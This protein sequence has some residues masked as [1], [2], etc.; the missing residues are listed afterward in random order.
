MNIKNIIFTSLVILLPFVPYAQTPDFIID[1]LDA[2]MQREMERWQIPGAAIAIVKDGEII[3]SRGFG[4]TNTKTK[5]MVNDE[6]LFMVASNSKAFTG[7]SLA[8]LENQGKISLDDPITRYLPWLDLE[9]DCATEMATIKDMLTHRIGFQTFQGD[10]LHWGSNLNRRELLERMDSH[11][12]QFQFR[13]GY[14]YCNVGFLAA[15]EVIPVVSGLS[16]DDFV[17]TQIFQ[18]LGMSRSSTT[19]HALQEDKNAC[20]A[21]TLNR[22]QLEE[23]PYENIDNLG[24]AASINSCV[25]DLAQWLIMNSQEGMVNNVQLF[26]AEVIE[27]TTTPYNISGENRGGLFPTHFE[28]YGLGWFMSDYSGK[29]MV[30]HDGGANGFVTTTCF[31][32]EIDLGIVVLTNTDANWFYEAM[33]IQI[34]EAYLGLPYR[35]ISATYH[36]FFKRGEQRKEESIQSLYNQ[37]HGGG[38]VAALP[39]SSYI[40]KYQD[41]VYGEIRIEDS[42]KGLRVFFEHHPDLWG[43]LESL[44]GNK[45]VCTYN[46]SIYGI[47]EVSFEVEKNQVKSYTMTVE[48]FIDYMPYTFVKL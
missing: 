34:V 42:G 21:Y 44:G 28:L 4:V 6:T 27:A 11:T 19:F 24:P 2:F 23:I 13:N 38:A 7:T 12:A 33:K 16:W 36:D 20:L 30:W 40:G 18:P 3:V 25:K 32:P 41:A 48:G 37:A 8:L 5:Q 1:S 9:D 39:L 15:G 45:F 14:G 29:K 10:F 43:D 35:N 31:L 26:P 47:K 17:A 22:G 46:Q